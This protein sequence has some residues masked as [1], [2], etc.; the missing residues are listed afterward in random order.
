M[1]TELISDASSQN[2]KVN[3]VEPSIYELVLDRQPQLNALNLETLAGLKKALT[4][5]SKQDSVRVLLVKGG[6]EKSFV[7]GAD[8][9]E[10]KDLSPAQAIAFSRNGHEVMHLLERFPA[11]TIA[12]IQGFA[13]GGGFELA[14]CC[15]EMIAGE[16]A[17]F[18]L[19][20]V[21]LGIIPG[22]GG[23]FRLAKWV[24]F[25]RA[26]ELALSGRRF[27][28]QEAKAMGLVTEVYTQSELNDKVLIKARDYATKSPLAVRT[29]KAL[30]YEHETNLGQHLRGDLEAQSFGALMGTKDQR[31]GMGAF[32]EKR[33]PQF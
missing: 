13:L 20:E 29:A 28:A 4:F 31:E 26:K 22:F 3:R 6:G 9:A 19:P 25:P 33:K 18:G 2:I 24:G 12:V 17:L 32:V 5:L 15:D 21:S 7:A 1:D 11:P 14:L 10:M 30:M 23:T 16:K 8:I 27:S